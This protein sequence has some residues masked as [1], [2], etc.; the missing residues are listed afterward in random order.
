VTRAA[1]AALVVLG[2]TTPAAVIGCV[3][4][5]D[6]TKL[7]RAIQASQ[8]QRPDELPVLLNREVPVRYPASLYAT[9]AQGNVTLR[10]FIDSLGRARPESTRV[11]ESSGQPA[12]DS[13]AVDGV[14]AL[15]FAPAKRQGMPVAVSILF[16][17]F[18]RHPQGAPVPGDSVL[19]RA[20]DPGR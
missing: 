5:D 1:A 6:A 8:P 2:V 3:S 4:K 15:R 11:A 9:R 7:V 13:A 18:F 14:A 12:F 19:L 10:I 17:V 16:P 20:A